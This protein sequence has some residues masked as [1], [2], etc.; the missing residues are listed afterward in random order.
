MADHLPMIVQAESGNFEKSNTAL[1]STT[2]LVSDFDDLYAQLTKAVH[3]PST[4]P[5]DA[6]FAFM[7][8]LQFVAICQRE[9]SLGALTLFRGYQGDSM[10]HLRR[11]IDSCASACRIGEHYELAK[12]WLSAGDGPEG[13]KRYRKEFKSARLFPAADEPGHN[14]LLREIYDRYDWFSKIMHVSLYGVGGHIQFHEGSDRLGF[15]MNIF[16]LP[17]GHAIV[18]AFYMILDTHKR[19]LLLLR[20]ALAPFFDADSIAQWQ[21]EYQFVLGRLDRHREIWKTVVPNPL[22]GQQLPE[23]E[24]K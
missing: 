18:S 11:A 23:S 20:A 3:Y 5:E 14:P 8:I 12:V 15:D 9:L 16:D 22:V 19:I 13:Y 7:A 1:G 24:S 2:K 10:L 6:Q 17:S 21:N 4:S